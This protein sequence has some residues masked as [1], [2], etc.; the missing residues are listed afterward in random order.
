MSQTRSF[1]QNSVKPISPA[2][3][4]ALLLSPVVMSCFFLVYALAGL[5]IEGRDKVNWAIEAPNVALYTTL[6][7]VTYCVV[8]MLYARWKGASRDHV[9]NISSVGHILLSV[10]LLICVFVTVKL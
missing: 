5:V 2:V 3:Q 10:L 9:L 6:G 8:V 7:I 1:P 4:F